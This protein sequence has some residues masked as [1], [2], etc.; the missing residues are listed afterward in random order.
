MRS[1]C[2]LVD[3]IRI[4]YT[5]TPSHGHGLAGVSNPET[6]NEL[7]NIT[8]EFKLRENY[9]NV[10]WHD[11]KPNSLAHEGIH[12]EWAVE[13]CKQAGAELVLVV[14]ADEIWDTVHLSNAI[15]TAITYPQRSF[16]VYMMHFWRSLW[17]VCNDGAAPTRLI[18]PNTPPEM[19]EGYIHEGKVYHMGYAQS[20]EIIKY[21]QSIHG[22][23]NEWRKDWF[24][25]VFLPWRPGDLADV[26]PTSIDYWHPEPYG[27]FRIP[28][29]FSGHLYLHCDIIEYQSYTS[30]N[31]YVPAF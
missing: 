5:P 19:G 30:Q 13:T 8:Q 3:E 12:R 24:E 28:H 23:K 15:A 22:H 21:K 6:R 16:R 27:D 31:P 10:F 26:H 2:K 25:T 7:L 1:V 14:D 20:P 18:K 11:A 17:W 4:F 9:P 29:L